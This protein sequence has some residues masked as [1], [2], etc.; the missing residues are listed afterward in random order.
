MQLWEAHRSFIY[1]IALQY[2]GYA[3]M[4]DLMQEGYLGLYFAAIRFDQNAGRH[5]LLMRPSGSASGC[6]DTLKTAVVRS[7]YLPEWLPGFG[8]TENYNQT[9]KNSLVTSPL[10]T[11]YER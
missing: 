4:D 8:N 6:A 5:F 10:L 2:S 11:R 7:G 1:K 3:E 9:I